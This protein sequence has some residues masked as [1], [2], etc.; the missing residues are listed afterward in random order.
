MIKGKKAW[1]RIVEAFIAVLLIAGFLI[2]MVSRTKTD[3]RSEEIY[4]IQRALLE[5]IERT[6]NY[7]TEIVAGSKTGA[8]EFIK[9]NLPASLDFEVVICDIDKVCGM[10][11]HVKTNIYV[12]EILIS[13]TLEKYQPKKLKLFVWEK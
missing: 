8:E 9:D 12:D 3:D 7:R 1:L 6:D 5:S 11:K 10:T 4:K 13:S 2:F